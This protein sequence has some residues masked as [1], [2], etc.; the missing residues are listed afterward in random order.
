M[1][2]ARIIFRMA[3][4]WGFLIL[5]PMYF[6]RDRMGRDA[7]PPITHAE[8]FYGFLGV[9]LVMQIIFL[10]IASDPQRFRPLM[11]PSVPEKIVFTAPAAILY[12]RG[13]LPASTFRLSLTDPLWGVLFAV[14]YVKTARMGSELSRA[15]SR[16]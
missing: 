14:A 2:F 4:V 15:P 3:A 6:L 12:L 9:A 7:P 16:R 10:I 11:L 13:E 8:Y 1:K 5:S